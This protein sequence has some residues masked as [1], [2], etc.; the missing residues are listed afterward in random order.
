ML[1]LLLSSLPAVAVGGAVVFAYMRYRLKLQPGPNPVSPIQVNLGEAEKVILAVLEGNSALL[2]SALDKAITFQWGAGD[3]VRTVLTVA[4]LEA[5]R[6]VKDPSV[7]APVIEMLAFVTGATEEQVLAVIKAK[8][9]PPVAVAPPAVVLPPAPV[10]VAGLALFLYL[11]LGSSASAAY[12]V[13]ANYAAGPSH[14]HADVVG[15]QRFYPSDRGTVVDPPLMRDA[16]GQLVEY[17]PVAYPRYATGDTP[18]GEQFVNYE[19][20]EGINDGRYVT[21]Y[22]GGYYAGNGYWYPG[23][24]ITRWVRN[25]RHPIARGGVRVVGAVGRGVARVARGA[26]RVVS[27][28]FRWIFRRRCG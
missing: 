16:R 23:K 24:L 18:I 13:G 22:Q 4:L 8:L 20:P 1:S 3:K 15:P 19:V 6:R 14:W 9:L 21:E 7:P 26:G 25:G 5:E 17:Q 2:K 12:P 11:C 10:V 28:P 27:A